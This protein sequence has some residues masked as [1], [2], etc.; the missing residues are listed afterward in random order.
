MEA[1]QHFNSSSNALCTW[2]EIGVGI[3]KALRSS[4]YSNACHGKK[5]LD[6]NLRIFRWLHFVCLI[7]AV[8]DQFPVFRNDDKLTSF[9][10]YL[11]IRLC[12][13]QD[14]ID[15]VWHL[16]HQDIVYSNA[17]SSTAE[18]YGS[19]KIWTLWLYWNMR[20]VITEKG[21][22]SHVAITL[23]AQHFSIKPWIISPCVTLVSKIVSTF[24]SVLRVLKSLVILSSFGSI[25]IWSVRCI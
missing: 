7:A 24:A 2:W 10:G 15:A 1:I 25:I 8:T 12:T 4:V 14:H 6:L 21:A 17:C 16:A 19:H 23:Q 3:G 13:Q 9:G 20:G 22:A 5:C 11:T 18:T